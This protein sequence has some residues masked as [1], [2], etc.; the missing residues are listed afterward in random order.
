MVS[1][2]QKMPQPKNAKNRAGDNFLLKQGR[3]M[4]EVKLFEFQIKTKFETERQMKHGLIDMRMH[5]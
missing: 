1:G 5:Y 3:Q 2:R 4:N